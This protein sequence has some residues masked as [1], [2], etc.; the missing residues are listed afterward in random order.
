ME[1]RRPLKAPRASNGGGL[2]GPRPF[3]GPANSWILEVRGSWKHLP[4]RCLE[5]FEPRRPL[6]A[7]A[8]AL[9]GP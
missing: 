2:E 6:K 3:K 1:A 9:E 4:W 8:P 7:E 5:A